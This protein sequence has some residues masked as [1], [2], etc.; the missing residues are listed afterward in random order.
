M[1]G[2]PGRSGGPRENSVVNTKV[3]VVLPV[4]PVRVPDARRVATDVT[5]LASHDDGRK[6]R[7]ILISS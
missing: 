6:V 5:P 1:T 4:L 2:Q 7:V 3:L